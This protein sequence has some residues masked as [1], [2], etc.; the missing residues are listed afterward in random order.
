MPK[1]GAVAFASVPLNAIDLAAKVH[2]LRQALEPDF[3]LV[4]E[5]PA[6]DL[7]LAYELYELL[8]KPVEA[9]W[10]PSKSLI[11]VTNGALGELPLGLLPTA[12]AQ[13][14]VHA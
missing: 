10:G 6:F 11:V 8:L 5:I 12:P 14:D 4:S 9:A 7:T 3:T 2:R 1:D 13:V